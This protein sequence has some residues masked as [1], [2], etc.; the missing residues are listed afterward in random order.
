MNVSGHTTNVATMN[1]NWS[2]NRL[3]ISIYNCELSSSLEGTN[4]HPLLYISSAMHDGVWNTNLRHINIL[5]IY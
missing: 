4:N 3:F 5:F 1:C 2:L